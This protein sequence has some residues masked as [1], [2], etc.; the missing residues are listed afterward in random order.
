MKSTYWVATVKFYLQNT[1]NFNDSTCNKNTSF[2]AFKKAIVLHQIS[3]TRE[4]VSLDTMRLL[5]TGEIM[6]RTYVIKMQ[7]LVYFKKAFLLHYISATQADKRASVTEH[8]D[9]KIG[10]T[11]Q[12]KT[13]VPYIRISF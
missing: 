7:S 9:F 8:N 3:T 4:Q 6:K 13:P 5:K 10:K 2:C 11:G 12:L 1:T